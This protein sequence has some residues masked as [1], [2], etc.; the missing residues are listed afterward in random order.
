MGGEATAGPPL[1]PAL[2]PLGVNVM[3][4]VKKINEVTKDY[5]GMR[6]PVKVIVDTET[7]EFEVEVGIPTTS[8]L[9]IKEASI[10]KGSDSSKQN[11]VGNL[12]FDQILKIS[13][14]KKQQSYGFKLPSVI[15]EVIGSCISMGMK[16][17]NKDPREFQR[18][19][20][21]G[22]WDKKIKE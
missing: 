18:E 19:F 17:E 3:S 1:G 7:K 16:I 8:A 15:G 21:E 14:I 4:I 5:S 12:T 6:A 2:G 20:Q 10:P 22:K 13:Q 11:F 9:I